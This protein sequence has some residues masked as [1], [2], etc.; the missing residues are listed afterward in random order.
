MAPLSSGRILT[1]AFAK[2]TAPF[3]SE[4]AILLTAEL[5]DLAESQRLCYVAIEEA[6]LSHECIDPETFFAQLVRVHAKPREA[7][8]SSDRAL[9]A[10][11]FALMAFAKRYEADNH[12]ETEAYSKHGTIL[13]GGA[14]APTG[15]AVQSGYLKSYH[16]PGSVPSSKLHAIQSLHPALDRGSHR[17]TYRFA[18]DDGGL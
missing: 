17:A 18:M 8:D 7:L 6:L 13:H 12:R 3:P 15:R 16:L 11:V 4:Q 10:L 9:L 5:P 14:N 2:D 1:E